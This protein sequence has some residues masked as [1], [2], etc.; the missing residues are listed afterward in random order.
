MLNTYCTSNQVEDGTYRLKEN[1]RYWH[2]VQGQLHLAKKT[3]CYFTTWTLKQ[4][5]VTAIV[6]DESWQANMSILE[7]FYKDKMLPNLQ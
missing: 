4:C 7:A 2:Q 3:T 1:H 6:R 5:V